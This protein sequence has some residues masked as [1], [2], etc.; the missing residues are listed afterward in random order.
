M[1]EKIKVSM[2]LVSGF[3]PFFHQTVNPSE[4]VVSKIQGQSQVEVVVLPVEFKKAYED[5]QLA[6]DHVKPKAIVMLGLAGGRS[7]ISLEKIALNWNQTQKP[8]ESGFIPEIAKIDAQS[9]LAIMTHFPVDFLYEFLRKHEVECEISFSAGTFVCN[10]LYYH[11]LKNN[12][13]IPSL[14]VHLPYLTQQ[15]S[16]GKPRM[17]LSSMLFAIEKIIQ[18]LLTTVLQTSK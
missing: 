4:I 6:I 9:E 2:I 5:L 11:V 17:E 14:F 15:A 18:F 10:N 13:D 12:P 16:T 1:E 8:D 3:K 7:R